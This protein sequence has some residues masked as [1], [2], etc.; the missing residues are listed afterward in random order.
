MAPMSKTPNIQMCSLA[1]AKRVSGVRDPGEVGV[2]YEVY[3]LSGRKLSGLALRNGMKPI[4]WHP[5]WLNAA[6]ELSLVSCLRDLETPRDDEWRAR[7]LSLLGLSAP[8]QGTHGHALS[9]LVSKSM[10]ATP[11][12]PARLRLALSGRPRTVNVQP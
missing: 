1:V 3:Q 11:S 2:C 4:G 5:E 9:L 6:D 12:H 8:M 7:H 10:F